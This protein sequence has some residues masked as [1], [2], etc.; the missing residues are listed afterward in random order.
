MHYPERVRSIILT[1][2]FPS[3]CVSFRRAIEIL[4]EACGQLD[5]ITFGRLGKWMIFAQ[6]FQETD[7]T[8]MLDS[9]LADMAAPYPIPGYAYKAQC[10][11][12]LGFDILKELP[13]VKAPALVV[14]GDRDLF[15]PVEVTKAMCDAIPGAKLYMA[16]NGGHVQHWEQLEKYNQITL[17]FLLAQLH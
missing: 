5:G 14:G 10:N 7:E 12:I 1:N 16:P 15:V 8:Y 6:P 3:C 11:A 2:T 17:D 13:K 9:E 4:R